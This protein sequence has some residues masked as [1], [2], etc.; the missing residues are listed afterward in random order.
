M[1]DVQ[2]YMAHKLSLDQ[3]IQC[4][5]VHV[6]YSKQI[7]AKVAPEIAKKLH[8]LTETSELLMASVSQLKDL[9]ALAE[10]WKTPVVTMRPRSSNTKG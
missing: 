1:V 8:A 10:Q 3:L 7:P 6:I 2:D 9:K 5:E 4:F